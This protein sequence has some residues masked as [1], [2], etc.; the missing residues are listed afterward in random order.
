[1]LQRNYPICGEVGN[2]V[3]LG[4]ISHNTT[5]H[6]C[7]KIRRE[8][9]ELTTI[10]CM[11]ILLE[12]TN[13]DA[14]FPELLEIMHHAMGNSRSYIFQNE[15]DNRLGICMSQI[16]EVVTEGIMPQIDNPVLKHLPYSHGL[17]TLLPTLQSRQHYAH[18][19]SELDD[20]DRMI[21]AEQSILSTM[22]LP[23]FCGSSLWGF[24]GFDDCVEVRQWFKKDIDLL[25]VVADAIGETI[26]RQQMVKM[27]K[28]KDDRFKAFNIAFSNGIVI[29]DK[30]IIVD[31]NQALSKISGYT[32][33][34][35]IGMDVML[36]IAE[37]YRN[38]VIQNIRSGYEKS[39]KV[40]GLHKNGT[41]H[42]L[43]VGAKQMTYMG[44]KVRVAEFRDISTQDS[45]EKA[46]REAR[47][48]FKQIFN[49]TAPLCMCDKDYNILMV[50][51]IFCDYIH[52]EME[53][54]I[55][56]KCYDICKGPFCRTPNCPMALV[57]KG[58]PQYKYEYTIDKKLDDGLEISCIVNSVPYTSHSGEI[59]GLIWNL[60]NITE[61]REAE[62]AIVQAKIFVDEAIRT[63]SEFL[64]NMSHELHTPLTAVIG[65]SDLL[66]ME[67]S[68]GLSEKQLEF[69]NYINK[70][71]NQLCKLIDDLLDISQVEAGKME[72]DCEELLILEIFDEIQTLMFPRAIEKNINLNIK[73]HDGVIFADRSKFKQIMCKLLSN[74]IKFTPDNGNVSVVTEQIGNVFQVSVSDTG[75]GIPKNKQEEIFTLF[76]QLDASNKRKYRG[77]G[78]GITLANEFVKMHGGKIKVESE[79]GK[80]STFTF[81]IPNQKCDE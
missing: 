74:A 48:D 8:E 29:H 77:I 58:K 61:R 51:D 10:Q 26:L 16:C 70:S 63:K 53:N 62:M 6:Q 7:A 12:S 17:T 66:S 15:E 39:Y 46:L 79:E 14:I 4:S 30:G 57:I 20:Q 9:Y 38:I 2:H 34:E 78:V 50:N 33:E 45:L 55:G 68:D 41:E 49:A 21:L 28:E 65:F 59:I 72:L 47:A 67:M 11:R 24:I 56:K 75:I 64:A 42:P 1:M 60:T 32:I 52:M 23:I 31:C 19:T 76:K 37:E 69:V 43:I 35:L 36:L 22:I 3:A 18:A 27:L 5:D 40:N 73:I 25:R 44:N 13:I 54:L 80:G 71:G 81:S